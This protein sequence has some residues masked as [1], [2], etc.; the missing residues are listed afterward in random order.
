M[1]RKRRRIATSKNHRQ[2]RFSMMESRY[3]ANR[4]TIAVVSVIAACFLI[5]GLWTRWKAFEFGSEIQT[6]NE[7]LHQLT[8]E[9]KYLLIQV[10]EMTDQKR[11]EQKAREYGLVTPEA[12]QIIRID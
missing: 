11:L 9:N 10:A 5:F 7:T 1:P 4:A 8:Q 6:M 2:S 12:G 3:G